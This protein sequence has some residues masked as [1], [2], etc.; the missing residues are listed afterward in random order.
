MQGSSLS[1]IPTIHVFLGHQKIAGKI[2]FYR[3]LWGPCK[4]K[5]VWGFVGGL[6][7]LW[8]ELMYLVVVP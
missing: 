2:R 5:V 7:W 8:P 6:S 1:Q 4:L 3:M